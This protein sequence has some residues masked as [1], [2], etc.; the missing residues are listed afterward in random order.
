MS[1]ELR[2]ST[3]Q[4]QLNKLAN[5]L[6][7]VSEL[8]IGL[9]LV[10]G[11][12]SELLHFVH[13]VI[14]RELAMAS[15]RLPIPMPECSSVVCIQS[16][17]LRQLEQLHA[18]R[19]QLGFSAP[20]FEKYQAV[21]RVAS[22][23][24]DWTNAAAVSIV[25]QLSVVKDGGCVVLQQPAGANPDIEGLLQ[26]R[27]AAE[28]YKARI[29]MFCPTVP[30]E[31]KFSGLANEFYVVTP[32]EPNPGFEEAFILSCPELAGSLNQSAGRVLCSV[33]LGDDGLEAEIG[34]YV[35][36]DLKTRL[37]AILK[38]DNWSLE[39]IGELVGLNKSNV[40]RK[41]RFVST[42]VPDGWD[43]A[44]LAEWLEA[45]GLDPVGTQ[46]ASEQATDV[47]D[48][49]DEI[50]SSESDDEGDDLNDLDH[51]KR[52]AT[53][54]RNERNTRNKEVVTPRKQR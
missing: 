44:M 36:G 41:L 5:S 15:S 18:L 53:A 31:A 28:M 7:T 13:F 22:C 6:G 16:G 52:V 45:C 3:K 10:A 42:S 50:G 40:S 26:L 54:S 23:S 2:R 47:D 48:G 12:Y 49:G 4:K 39:K 9:T 29:I 8:R 30:A 14:V 34:P 21:D 51:I 46:R 19:A 37:M 1:R 32:C 11:H 25:R 43:E 38:A 17:P 33:R 24:L 20:E 27:R 35:A